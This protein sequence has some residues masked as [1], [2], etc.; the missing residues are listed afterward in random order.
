LTGSTGVTGA[1]V[2]G[3]TGATGTTGAT[4]S[5]GAAGAT[6]S[7]GGTGATGVQTP[8]TSTID[9]ANYALKNAETITFDQELAQTG[10]GGTLTVDLTAAQKHKVTLTAST[11]LAFT[12]P[13]GVG[14]FL[15]R[16]V[17]GGS[18]SYAITW[19]T[20]GQAAGNF[21]WVGKTIIALSTAVGAE[22]IVSIYYNGSYYDVSYGN[23][24]G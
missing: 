4:G 19:P 10:A 2:T 5:T 12:A 13:L 22:D 16:I 18:G 20:Q 14:N 6:G 9:G 24:F 21:A 7:S 23:N 17:Q 3:S 1:G 15:L 11:T 8:W